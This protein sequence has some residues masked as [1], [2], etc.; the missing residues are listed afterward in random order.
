MAAAVCIICN[1]SDIARC[2][3]LHRWRR[4]HRYTGPV[5]V[6]VVVP[7]ASRLLPG[8]TRI[9]FFGE[10]VLSRPHSRRM[11]AANLGMAE[12]TEQTRHEHLL[13]LYFA[14]VLL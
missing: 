7:V 1:V 5:V 12:D 11:A 8:T 14:I 3:L 6:A 4:W 10:V 13:K 9:D 2:L